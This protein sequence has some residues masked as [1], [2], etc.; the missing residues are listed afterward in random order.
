MC[1]MWLVLQLAVVLLYWDIPSLDSVPRKYSAVRQVKEEEEQLLMCSRSEDGTPGSGSYNMVLSDQTET[2]LLE[3]LGSS[4]PEATAT[5]DSPCSLDDPFED[6][7]T[8]Q[9][10]F[11]VQS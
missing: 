8:S 6:F 7:S 10:V 5:L 2:Q 9:G 3:D 1:T 4:E 11:C